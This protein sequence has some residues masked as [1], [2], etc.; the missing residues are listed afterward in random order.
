MTEV[1]DL[2]IDPDYEKEVSEMTG[3]LY[4]Y[5]EGETSISFYEELFMRN[6]K[7]NCIVEDGGSCS[8]VQY[9]VESRNESGIDSIGVIDGD[10]ELKDIDNVFQI[11]YYSIENLV[12]QH[13][14]QFNTLKNV[15]IE[16]YYSH[17]INFDLQNRV[18]LSR[19]GSS[20]QVDSNKILKR[21]E[22]IYINNKAN[23]LQGFIKYVDFKA[24]VNQYVK[25]VTND[26]DFSRPYKKQIKK[27]LEALHEHYKSVD[28]AFMFADDTV[29]K[30]W[31]KLRQYRKI[32]NHFF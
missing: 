14:S 21:S 13:H 7:V 4:I 25:S 27:Y 26:P 20:V 6:L 19:D 5:C 17:F 2:T 8:M 22:I 29:Q 15:I 9:T 1:V 18:F 3:T 28:L 12:L 24:C 10:Y 32:H 23:T 30:L 16:S 31:T 11:D